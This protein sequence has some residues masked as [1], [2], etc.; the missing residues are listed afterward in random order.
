M[1]RNRITVAQIVSGLDLGGGVQWIAYLLASNLNS[2]R[3]RVIVCCLQNLGELGEKLKELGIPVFLFNGRSSINPL[4][5]PRNFFVMC[6]LIKL[7]RREKVQI[8]HTHE[9]FSG[10]L[11]RISAKL[12]KSS[13]TLLM[14]HKK[15]FW[16][17]SIHI[18]I[19]KILVNWTNKIVF[20]S[21][22]VK[23]FTMRQYGGLNPPDF[24]V[25]HNGIDITKFSPYISERKTK[26]SDLGIKKNNAPALVIV[27][28]LSIEKGHCYLIKAL[29]AIVEKFPKLRLLIVGDESPFDTSTKEEIFQLVA[30]LGLMKNVVFL[31]ERKDVPEILC[32]I[33]ILVSP[34]LLEG[35]GLVIA[36]AMAA[37]KPVIASKVDGIPEVVKDGV[38]GILVPPRDSKALANAI[39]FLLCN[40]DKAKKMGKAGKERVN[41]YFSVETMVKKWDKLYQELA[42]KKG[43]VSPIN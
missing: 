29:P 2:N 17:K 35:F 39:L 1:V 40:P 26:I 24:T 33:N 25:V 36:E 18:C 38:T 21:H 3:Y 14:L 34:S 20:N 23:D 10:T 5:F 41:Q 22:S 8:V 31:G 9:F 6:S 7:L 32:V 27:G 16:K 28:R 37:G 15:D 13:I 19:D 12:A 43:I 42:I 11:G 30:T 4:H